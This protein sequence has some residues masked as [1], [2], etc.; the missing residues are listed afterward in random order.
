M[1][2]ASLTVLR[3]S[4]DRRRAA[5]RATLLITASLTATLASPATAGARGWSE[6]RRLGASLLPR[7][8]VGASLERIEES[9]FSACSIVAF[10]QLSWPFDVAG[11]RTESAALAERRR[12]SLRREH[13]AGRIGALSRKRAT[14]AAA[15]PSVESALALEETDAE[16]DALGEEL[17]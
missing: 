16:L 6:A 8:T 14:L 15:P 13:V 12:A 7:L 9:G 5:S 17:P 11:A 10:A 2:T 4:G 3:T 1:H